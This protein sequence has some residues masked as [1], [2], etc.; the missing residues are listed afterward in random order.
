[1]LE[2]LFS[3][4]LQTG[5]KIHGFHFFAFR[6]IVIGVAFEAARF[7][8]VRAWG[9]AG[10]AICQR[11]NEHVAGVLAGERAGVAA[12]AGEAAVSIVIEARVRHPAFGEVG[13]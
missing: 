10:F 3:A 2:L 1:M 9:V 4:G 13:F 11:R 6:P 5:E 8:V 7:G 12:D